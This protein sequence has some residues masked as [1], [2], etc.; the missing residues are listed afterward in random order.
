MSTT[1]GNIKISELNELGVI[2]NG[3]KLKIPVSTDTSST[4]TPDWE[5]YSINGN[6]LSSFM[7]KSLGISDVGSEKGLRSKVNELEDTAKKYS[8]LEKRLGKYN[9]VST[10]E[11]SVAMAGNYISTSGTRIA[12]PDYCISTTVTLEQ[13]NLYL[14]YIDSSLP[15]LPKDIAIMAKVDN[16][17]YGYSENTGGWSTPLSETVYEPIPNHYNSSANGGYGVPDY[18]NFLVF[19]ATEN[20]NVV[21]S[22]NSASFNGVNNKLYIVKYGT[23][24]DIA[25]NLL[26]INGELMKVIVEAIVKNRKDIDSLY[27]K[28]KSLG[29]IHVTS[30]DSD[31]FPSVQGESMV[32]VAD[33]SPSAAGT[34]HG[35]D[36][37]NRIGQIW[38]D[39]SSGKAYIAVALGLYGWK[40]ITV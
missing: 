24:V 27:D 32:V 37:P 2:G 18:G 17:I 36:I 20:K 38:V 6:V 11:L 1:T 10:K 9:T 39:V 28:T 7:G 12:S 13:G 33:R 3:A 26:S 22:I 19:F 25:D 15:T 31:E 14:L 29:D 21:F 23:F 5:S 4:S 35:D 30:I 40:Q 16:H 8:E 34:N